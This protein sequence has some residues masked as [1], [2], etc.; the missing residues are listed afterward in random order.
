MNILAN[1]WQ[2]KIQ[3]EGVEGLKS[4]LPWLTD[5]ISIVLGIFSCAVASTDLRL[6][7]DLNKVFIR[8]DFPRPLCPVSTDRQADSETDTHRK[9]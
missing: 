5:F 2:K 6:T 1:S 8:V 7:L 4:T 9:T 3:R